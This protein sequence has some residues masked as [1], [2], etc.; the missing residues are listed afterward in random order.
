MLYPDL[1]TFKSLATKGNLIPVY[2]EILADT[3]TP[4]SAAL[5]LGGLPSFLLES[6][7][8]GEK[9]ARYS[10]L[11][12]RPSRIIKSWG[13]NVEIRDNEIGTKLFE[14]ENPFNFIKKEITAFN[15]VDVIGLP[16]FYGGLVGYIGYDMVR[17]F[18]RIPDR[19]KMP[20]LELPDMFFMVTDTVVIFDNLKGKIKVVSNAYVNNKSPEEAC[21]GEDRKY[22]RKTET[23][24][25]QKQKVKFLYIP[26]H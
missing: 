26:S 2:K 18:E 22:H 25:N 17:F 23:F 1:E 6:V 20:G 5:K 15:P 16:R 13:K 3:E 12:S 14:V 4:V 9:W 19:E 8:G 24:R 21:R 10:F 11:G 7:V